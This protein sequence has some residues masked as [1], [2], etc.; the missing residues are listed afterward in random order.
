GATGTI[1]TVSG[2]AGPAGALTVTANTGATGIFLTSINNDNGTISAMVE[3]GCNTPAGPNIV[4]LTVRDGAGATATASLSVVVA[5]NTPPV[6][7]TYPDTTLDPGAGVVTPDA[8]P[9]DNG[10]IVSL[11]V[12]GASGLNAD[13]NTGVITVPAGIAA[14]TYPITVTATD[15]CGATATRTF[16]LTI[17][18]AGQPC[19]TP[20]FSAA[21]NY[22]AGVGPRA[23]AAADFN[24]DGR[25][26]LAVA[27]ADGNNV[28][29]LLALAAGGYAPALHLASGNAPRSLA[30]GDFNGDGKTDLVSANLITSNLSIFAG[31]GAGGFGAA[32][33]IAVG[34][35]PSAVVTGD[36]NGDEKPD[37]AV[38]ISGVRS[39][40]VLLGDGT[41]GFGAPVSYGVDTNPIA[42]L[43]AD[44]NADG[45]PDLAVANFDTANVSVLLGTGLGTFNAAVNYVVGAGPRGIATGDFNGDGR[46]DLVTANATGNSISI[47]PGD[48]AGAFG[49]ATNR[50]A[51]TLPRGVATGDFNGDGKPDLALTFAQNRNIAILPGDGAGGFGA[52]MNLAAGADPLGILVTDLNA[53]DKP[54]M[55]AAN[56]DS[57]N[58]SVFL[59]NTPCAASSAPVIIAAQGL[60]RRQG[61]AL[62]LSTIATVRDGQTAAGELRVTV[63]LLSPGITLGNLANNNGV[64]TAN[65]AVAANAPLGVARVLLTVTDASGLRGTATLIINVVAA[66]TAPAITINTRTLTLDAGATQS[67]AGVL[68][69]NDE[70]TAPGALGIALSNPGPGIEVSATPEIDGARL[71]LSLRVRVPFGAAGDYP[72][73][74]R[75]TDAEGLSATALLQIHVNNTAT[76]AV[77]QVTRSG[78]VYSRLTRTYNSVITVTNTGAQ[79]VAGP[80]DVRLLN[81]NSGVTL[82]NATGV[83]TTD[84]GAVVPYLSIDGG[85]QPGQ[86]VSL[87]AQFR[88]PNNELIDFAPQIFRGG[89]V[90]NMRLREDRSGARGADP[91]F[92]RQPPSGRSVRP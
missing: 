51:G 75:L 91:E 53:D 58:V 32:T 27:N 26:D 42:M 52:A 79:P 23:V 31:D 85:L 63:G 54:D 21:S 50:A 13:L 66:N 19:A 34:S 37:L 70:T 9:N 39:V 92:R 7:G 57:G 65:I 38:A 35:S 87:N 6:P 74:V 12:T 14:G 55:V 4:T 56:I 18:G 45:I 84:N 30:T 11:T 48:G 17:R 68:T 61:T 47:L 8:P 3:A 59:N 28:S 20:E 69:V 41:G 80:L 2:G 67:F 60:T 49:P 78:L 73:I 33:T 29:I 24:G 86:S 72:L 15:N 82:V 71:R 64:I 46:A 83:V 81:L 10:S 88:N 1:A 22:A 40:A 25:P 5:G 43:T 16:T 89:V 77:L 62:S 90:L 76:A 44:F 36:F